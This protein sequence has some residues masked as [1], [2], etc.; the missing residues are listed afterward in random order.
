GFGDVFV[1]DLLQGTTTLI[2][3]RT[4]GMFSAG[5]GASTSPVPSADGSAVAFLSTAT[6]LVFNNT[7]NTNNLFVRNLATGVTKMINIVP[8]GVS[9]VTVQSLNH[10]LSADGA[11]LAFR[12]ITSN[13]NSVPEGI[14]WVDLAND[15]YTPVGPTNLITTPR[16]GLGDFSGPVMSADGLALAFEAI[17]FTIPAGAR[18]IYSWNA[19]SGETLLVSF[20]NS[21]TNVSRNIRPLINADGTRIAFVSNAT[22]VFPN[23]GPNSF[24]IYVH[25]VATVSNKL[26]SL[27]ADGSPV[28]EGDLD[29]A[30]PSF[31][32]DGR[33]LAFQSR[34][35]D[36]VNN[37]GNHASDVFVRDLDT[38]T[39]QLVSARHAALPQV[40]GSALSSLNASSI[41]SNAQV[42][43]FVSEA[44]NLAPNDTNAL[45]DV[46]ARDLQSGSNLLVSVNF[47]GTGTG[48]GLSKWPAL[49]ANGRFV[50][51]VSGASNLV[52]DD[53]NAWD[54]VFVRDL[55]AGTTTR[56]SVNNDGTG[57]NSAIPNTPSPSADGRW[58]AYKDAGSIYVWD[59]QAGTNALAS[60]A[61]DGTPV[62]GDAPVISPDGGHVTFLS[63]SPPLLY[64]HDLASGTT[65]PVSSDPVAP[66]QVISGDS[67]L[68]VFQANA[69]PTNFNL[70]VH[71][72]GTTSNRL[73]TVAQGGGASTNRLSAKSRVS[74]DGR[75][76]AFLSE[77]AA[78]VAG[79]T[80]GAP[81]VFVA[82]LATG[83]IR[84]VSVDDNGTS[85][86]N[87]SSDSPD[88]S[89]DGRFVVF[90]SLASNLVPNDTNTQADVFLRDLQ[91]GTTTLLSGSS[92][93]YGSA[94]QRSTRPMI[95]ADGQVVL[96]NSAAS[97]LVN[98]DF[99]QAQ[100][101]FYFRNTAVTSD[102]D[103]DGMDDAWE[104]AY[105]NS[106]WR[107]GSGDFD[108]DGASDFAE[109]RAG[110]DPTQADSVFRGELVGPP[111]NGA[112]LVRWNSVPGRIYRLQFKN[113]LK[114][115]QWTDLKGDVIADSTTASKPDGTIGFLRQRYYRVLLIR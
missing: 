103:G 94:N 83:S 8:P 95:S 69:P 15:T 76:V 11:Y 93:G 58:V 27:S 70:Y 104:N 1:R 100:D 16:S 114:T 71:P 41:S 52:V 37:D 22:N 54:D 60:V 40:F 3:V 39:T 29:W 57:L 72:L 107:D 78:L 12:A 24:Q 79:D 38:D 112:V 84:L 56:I 7:R 35:A 28:N 75:F 50:A 67:A 25:E 97:D 17:P 98:N 86:G 46:F 63:G 30:A 48:N 21:T 2:S 33:V 85:A 77:D 55:Q 51:F 109:F 66:S 90:R 111:E 82:D 18:D 26:I 10:V 74:A 99:N 59:T 101:L 73:I 91:A 36:L 47:D 49:S 61:N 32:A 96:F 81:D 65:V 68:L 62:T 110:T 106:L 42:A 89:A 92:S 45:Q 14:Y 115:N 13:T 113:D 88:I 31:S 4:N 105:F 34:S 23:S 102:T 87:G 53:T 19:L 108:Q 64:D 5:G 20:P 43:V 44:D 80:N 9:N 6:N